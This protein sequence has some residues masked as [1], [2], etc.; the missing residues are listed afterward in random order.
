M[1]NRQYVMGRK[2]VDIGEIQEMVGKK[3][4]GIGNLE[5]S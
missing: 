2:R 4:R 5:T 1:Y 3:L